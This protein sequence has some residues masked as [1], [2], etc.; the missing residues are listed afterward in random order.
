MA[1]LTV[2]TIPSWIVSPLYVIPYILHYMSVWHRKKISSGRNQSWAEADQVHDRC[3]NSSEQNKTC[4]LS[5]GNGIN[6]SSNSKLTAVLIGA[7]DTR[8]WN[9]NSHSC[10]MS[11]PAVGT[12]EI[13]RLWTQ[14]S[15]LLNRRELI[16]RV[17]GTVY[18]LD[19]R[20][21]SQTL[22][23][24][25]PIQCMLLYPSWVF[26]NPTGMSHICLNLPK[27]QSYVNTICCYL[28]A[29]WVS[30]RAKCIM[31]SAAN[32]ALTPLPRAVL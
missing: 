11:G 24:S 2:R 17:V 3:I 25:P 7:Q 14:L 30:I 28:A 20:V 1:N 4:H 18:P 21:V 27:W 26:H 12:Q 16:I 29:D 23:I 9:S 15:F 8:L 22:A 10:C 5:D 19:W 6:Y 32:A 31:A 13:K